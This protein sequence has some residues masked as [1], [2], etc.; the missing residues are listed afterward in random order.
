VQRREEL[1]EA[2]ETILGLTIKGKPV[3]AV[4]LEQGACVLR[5]FYLAITLDATPIRRS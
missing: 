5:E 3:R 2:V 1:G 4:L